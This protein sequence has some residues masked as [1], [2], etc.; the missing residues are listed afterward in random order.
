MIT[1]MFIVNYRIF[2]FLMFSQPLTLYF[3]LE[4]FKA[5]YRY[6]PIEISKHVLKA[7]ANKEV[8]YM[9]CSC[10]FIMKAINTES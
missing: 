1:G 9:I 6:I 3:N 8:L 4:T 10:S 5:V 2:I 7:Q